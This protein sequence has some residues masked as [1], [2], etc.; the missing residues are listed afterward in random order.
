MARWFGCVEG[1][2]KEGTLYSEAG[3]LL[4]PAVMSLVAAVSPALASGDFMDRRIYATGRTGCGRTAKM[5]R[6]LLRSPPRVIPE[7]PDNPRDI[8][9]LT[10]MTLDRE[11]ELTRDEELDRTSNHCSLGLKFKAHDQEFMAA[12]FFRCGQVH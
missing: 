10:A 11:L 3:E 6:L 2:G 12:W 4:R 5:T 1:R 8:V 7:A 9:W